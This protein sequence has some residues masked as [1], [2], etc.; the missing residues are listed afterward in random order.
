[1]EKGLQTPETGQRVETLMTLVDQI[2]RGVVDIEEDGIKAA[3]GLLGIE[4]L[5]CSEREKVTL[6][7]TTSRIGMYF[8]PQWYDLL[9]MP[10]DH[11]RQCFYHNEF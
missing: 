6:D 4:S 3:P 5:A 1:M 8:L 9:L 11:C 2:S 7:K 10:S